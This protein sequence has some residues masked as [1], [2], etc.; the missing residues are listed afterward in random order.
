MTAYLL[1]LNGGSS[2]IKFALYSA[3]ESP[4]RALSGQIERI[5]LADA[6]LSA[7]GTP[8][9]SPL[10]QGGEGRQAIAARDH[11]QAGEHLMNWLDQR[12]GLKTVAAVGHRVVH[13]GTRYTEATSVTAE[14]VDE[15]RRLSPLDPAHLPGEIALI[16]ALRRRHPDLPQVACFDT[17]FHREMPRVATL[18]PIPRHYYAAG[19]RRY[20]FHGL[21][22]AYLMEEL[23]RSAGT[24]AARGRV[25]LAHLG[26]G[27]SLAAVRN[28]KCIDTTMA[29]TPTAGLVM[30]TRSGDLDPGVLIHLMR[31]E[32]LTADQL[33]ELV[34]RR[35]GLLGVSEISG[36]MRD[37]LGR[38]TSDPRAADAVELFC[39]QARKWVGA[40]AAA[41]GGLDTLV[42][43][44][45]IGENSAEVRARICEGLGFLGIKLD[46][47]RNAAHAAVIS[48]HTGSTAVRVIRTDE[49]AMIAREVYRLLGNRLAPPG[50]Q[51]G[52]VTHGTEGYERRTDSTDL[53]EWRGPAR[54]G[55][56]L[57][58]R[59]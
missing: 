53:E 24:E 10:P 8:S 35:S 19:V 6:F 7:K 57:G 5:G 15:L 42:F 36:D 2:S 26:A 50:N 13:G 4:E 1:T 25:I 14:L 23:A 44:G 27:A 18:L 56:A 54:S 55:A 37:L 59:T 38:Q 30:G 32:G 39:Y 40:F 41:L 12:V 11:E 49:E 46:E 58:G 20:G 48:T 47:D 52:K 45:G 43:A 33:D 28:G 16:D 21:S 9:P 29:F 17:A 22:Y 31:H 3:G 34:N 51:Q